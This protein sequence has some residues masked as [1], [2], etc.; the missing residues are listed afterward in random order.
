MFMLLVHI[1]YTYIY[2][3]IYDVY[4]MLHPLSKIYQ[5]KSRSLKSHDH[6]HGDHL[7]HHPQWMGQL[8]GTPMGHSV[9]CLK[10]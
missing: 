4:I 8:D 9:S 5:S 7:D 10:K 1:N 6:F 3:H 2:I